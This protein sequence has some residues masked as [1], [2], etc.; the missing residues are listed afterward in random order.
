MAPQKVANG[1][2]FEFHKEDYPTLTAL[3]LMVQND[4]ELIKTYRRWHPGTLQMAPQKVAN[5]LC[6]EFHKEDYPTLTAL[7]LMVQK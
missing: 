7:L 5:G 4:M 3:L 1:L 2:C 6:F